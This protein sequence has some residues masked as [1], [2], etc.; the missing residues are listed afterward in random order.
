MYIFLLM[1][2]GVTARYL[3]NENENGEWL[4]CLE[5]QL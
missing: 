4:K 3:T 2:P 5:K 1:I